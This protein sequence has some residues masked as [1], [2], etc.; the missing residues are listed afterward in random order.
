MKFLVFAASHRTDSY[1]R[2]LSK[3]AAAYLAAAGHDVDYADYREFDL[4]LYN[5][6]VAATTLPMEVIKT[7]GR[8]ANADGIIISAPE[9]N[10]S[11]PGTL[12]NLIDWLSRISPV[13]TRG[14]TVFLM[15]ASTSARG[16]ILGLNHLETP[17]EAIQMYVFPKMYPLGNA[18][19][20][21][22]S[23]TQLADSKQHAAFTAMLDEYRVFTQKLLQPIT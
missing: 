3:I 14:K 9:Y 20:A 18:A 21:F 8:F 19:T 6:E 23:A 11:Y 12:K 7:G 10:W 2:K 4:P 22:A 5:D 15:S 1:N 13:P 17:L 16:G